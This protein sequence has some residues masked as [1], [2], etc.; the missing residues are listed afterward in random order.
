MNSP[1]NKSF[2]KKTFFY[3]KTPI[4]KSKT[5]TQIPEEEKKTTYESVTTKNTKT[6]KEQNNSK[7]KD[8]TKIIEV[9][10]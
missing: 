7:Q 1:K 2:I 3:I 6:L 5:Q 9:G 4:R 10:R 8:H